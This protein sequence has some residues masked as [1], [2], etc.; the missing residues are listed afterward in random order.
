MPKVKAINKVLELESYANDRQVTFRIL[1]SDSQP[2]DADN[3]V[4]IPTGIAYRLYHL[5]RAY[6]FQT[7]KLMHP[8][9]RTRIDYVR[10]PLLT[11][12]LEHIAAIVNDPVVQHYLELLLPLLRSS[13]HDTKTALLVV[14][15]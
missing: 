3:S 11:S 5:G 9:A 7:I 12:E 13:R 15:Q 8:S 14:P 4:N 1:G 6:D 10:L 2:G